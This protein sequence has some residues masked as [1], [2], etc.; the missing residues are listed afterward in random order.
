MIPFVFSASSKSQLG[1]NFLGLVDSGR[2]KD[3]RESSPEQQQFLAEARACKYS[4]SAGL[5]RRL[6]WSVPAGSR[7]SNGHVLHDDWLMSAALCA[8]LEN[9]PLL[10]GNETRI[11]PAADPLREMDAGRENREW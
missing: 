5:E 11:I 7:D 4:V 1:W 8:V 2:F 10:P 9:D 6:M 3:H